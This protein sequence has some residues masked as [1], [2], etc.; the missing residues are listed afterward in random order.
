MD[1]ARLL[2][3]FAQN[4]ARLRD[5]AARDL[6]AP[7]PSCPGWTVTDLVRHVA[8]VYLHKAEAIR[9]GEWPEPW[10]PDFSG[11]E[12]I[13]LLERA[14]AALMAQFAAHS[15][16][17]KAMTWHGPDQTVG[18]WIRRMAQETLI[19]RVDA[20]LALGEPVA[21]IPDD[22]AVDGI[23]ELLQIFLSYGVDAWTEEFEATLAKSSGHN[24]GVH[25]RGAEWLIET[26]PSEVA[27]TTAFG[28]AVPWIAQRD[29]DAVVSGPTGEVLRWLWNRG[30]DTVTVRGDLAAIAE[31]RELL[32]I[33]SQ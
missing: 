8:Q 2:D 14:H 16:A 4:Y 23:D 26:G 5:V 33:A 18:F 6:T 15:P 10:P 17:D 19:H 12:P 27:V 31:L 1:N 7:V 3:Q 32:V 13:A 24:V 28:E 9:L 21:P 30:G 22:V 25:V 29:H 20:E 11:E